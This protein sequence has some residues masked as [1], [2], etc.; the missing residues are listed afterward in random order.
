M[1]LLE[2]SKV[3]KHK[4]SFKVSTSPA[5]IPRFST[6]KSLVPVWMDLL[7]QCTREQ[8]R[9]RESAFACIL[10]PAFST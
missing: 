9:E 2:Q 7:T 1:L 4:H 6:G 3:S 10:P 5:F 8:E